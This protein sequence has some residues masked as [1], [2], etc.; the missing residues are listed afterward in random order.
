MLLLVPLFQMRKCDLGRWNNLPAWIP[1]W[2]DRTHPDPIQP[3]P[4]TLWYHLQLRSA[5][6]QSSQS[7]Q[8]APTWPLSSRRFGRA[9]F[10]THELKASVWQTWTAQRGSTPCCGVI[11]KVAA[12]AVWFLSNAW[13]MV[14]FEGRNFPE[15][16]FLFPNICSAL[17]LGRRACWRGC[18]LGGHALHP[19]FTSLKGI[20]AHPL[21]FLKGAEN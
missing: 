7:G 4:L 20:V 19:H 6:T 17:G 15:V 12:E 13:D 21:G 9:C 18:R 11:R 5:V 8:K 1:H 14:A 10:S 16:Y 3:M 2:L